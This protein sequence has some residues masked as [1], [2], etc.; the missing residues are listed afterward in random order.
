VDEQLTVVSDPAQHKA[1]GHPMRHRLLFTLAREQATISQ[2][3]AGLGVNKGSVAHHLKVLRDAGLVEEAGSRQVRGGTERYYRR[4]ADRLSYD[5]PQSTAAAFQAVAAEVA[6]AS[7][8]PVLLLRTLRLS[9]EQ[10]AAI[11]AQ[12]EDLATQTSEAG[13]EHPQYRLLVGLY[14]PA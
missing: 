2:L 13:P 11:G 9:P 7:D 6:T 1:L 4:V 12:L 5:D 10:V 14:R 8:A 3:A